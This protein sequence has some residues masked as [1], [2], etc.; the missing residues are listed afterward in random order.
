MR[1]ETMNKDVYNTSILQ[2][3]LLSNNGLINDLI[4]ENQLDELTERVLKESEKQ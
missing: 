2:K 1:I 4:P 3:G